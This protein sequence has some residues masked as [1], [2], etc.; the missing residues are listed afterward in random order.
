MN[1]PIKKHLF[2]P[3]VLFLLFSH[4]H[5]DPQGVVPVD[6]GRYDA[7]LTERIKKPVYFDAKSLQIRRCTWFF[8]S[9]SSQR[10]TPFTEEA[11]SILEVSCC[12]LILINFYRY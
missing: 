10:F 12:F 3:F 7:V 5:L 2:H 9:E 4:L 6:G 8:R 11:S 1:R